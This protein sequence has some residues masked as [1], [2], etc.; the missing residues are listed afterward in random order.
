MNQILT[1]GD[2]AIKSVKSLQ[3]P[4]NESTFTSEFEGADRPLRDLQKR[5]TETGPVLESIL[6]SSWHHGGLND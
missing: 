5:A 1:P 6:V 4:S 2:L 3:N